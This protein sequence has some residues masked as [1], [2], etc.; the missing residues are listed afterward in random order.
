[1]RILLTGAEG[2]TGRHLCA[3]AERAGHAVQPLSVDLGDAAAV[4]QA[5][6]HAAQ[7]APFDAVLHLAGLAFVGHDDPLAFY[8]VNVMGT[9][10]LLQA[11]LAQQRRGAVALRQVVLAS[12]ANVYGNCVASP[13]D[14]GQTPAP[15]NHYAAS[16]LAMEHLALTLAEA[17]PL[18]L[19]RPFNYTGPGQ[20]VD[21]V[22]P[23][24]VA[25][26]QRRQA[27]LKLGSLHVERE[28]N[29]VGWVCEAY[30]RLLGLPAPPTVQ[31]RVV[32]LCSGEMHTLQT[33][34]ST[35]Q[36]LTGH[37]LTVETDPSLV[38]AHEVHRLCGN[39]ARLRAL[40]GPMATPSLAETLQT[41][42]RD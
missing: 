11:L 3:A 4:Q 24:M 26:F 33:V 8:R 30:L 2:F 23:K 6:E 19:V 12:S 27:V 7:E 5:V 17:L 36:A 38:R 9:M 41:M 16:K 18:R 35:L 25:H 22:I 29:D 15:V 42:L 34:L 39:P 28:Y 10:H 21:F 31:D 32:N 14:E 1:M 40:V 13:I 20:S 37:H